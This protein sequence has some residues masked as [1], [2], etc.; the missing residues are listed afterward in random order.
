MME[1]Q[2][3][4]AIYSIISNEILAFTWAG[5]AGLT[6]AGDCWH[7]L[8]LVQNNFSTIFSTLLVNVQW[9]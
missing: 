7:F 6:V 5:D 4:T 8:N 9:T 3:I 1:G 2:Q